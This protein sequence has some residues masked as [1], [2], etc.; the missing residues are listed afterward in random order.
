METW[1]IIILIIV[2]LFVISVIIGFF[3]D[4]YL[5]EKDANLKQNELKNS[6]DSNLVVQ[7]EQKVSESL[8]NSQSTL[9]N[10]TNVETNAN[11]TALEQSTIIQDNLVSSEQTLNTTTVMME[12]NSI[13]NMSNSGQLISEQNFNNTVNNVIPIQN[14]NNQFGQSIESQPNMTN[15]VNLSTPTNE[16]LQQ[17]QVNNVI[18]QT[19][20]NLVPFDGN[21]SADDNVNNVF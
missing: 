1:L 20:P 4:K 11:E 16:Q 13:N 6:N 12:N 10:S 8:N 9:E 18:N 3:G 14:I 19:D 15:G 21:F 7:K 2:I 17:N 5:K